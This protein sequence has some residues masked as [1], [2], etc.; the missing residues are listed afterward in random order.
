RLVRQ[1]L[2]G[3]LGLCD[4]VER[5]PHRLAPVRNGAAANPH[6][7]DPEQDR[8]R[9]PDHE[10]HD[11]LRDR[12]VQRPD[13]DRNPLVLLELRRRVEV[14]TRE[15]GC[16]KRKGEERGNE[17]PADHSPLPKY[18]TSDRPSSNVYASPNV[19]TAATASCASVAAIAASTTRSAIALKK[20][21]NPCIPAAATLLAR[22]CIRVTRALMACI[23]P[24]RKAPSA[25]PEIGQPAMRK[26]GS[27]RRRTSAPPTTGISFPGTGRGVA[28]MPP[29]IKS[30][31]GSAGR[32]RTPRAAGR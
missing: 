10:V 1:A 14:P 7:H 11:R 25:Q 23:A 12:Q 15:R 32:P 29:R 8:E 20:R 4:L 30:P 9:A 17:E 18:V 26:T 3:D 24:Q 28:R 2:L 31:P 5:L 16:G 22:R 6:Q 21:A 13:V 19:R 27:A